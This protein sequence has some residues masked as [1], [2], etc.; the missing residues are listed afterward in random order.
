MC[1]LTESMQPCMFM[2]TLGDTHTQ[3]AC[4]YIGLGSNLWAH[5]ESPALPKN[6]IQAEERNNTQSILTRRQPVYIYIYRFGFKS[7][8]SCREPSPA[9]KYYTG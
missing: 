5:A 1:G 6:T 8:G 2:E 7:V 4:L 3:A 9:K